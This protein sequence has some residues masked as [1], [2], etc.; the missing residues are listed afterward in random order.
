LIFLILESTIYKVPFAI[1]PAENL[2]DYFPLRNVE[3]NFI[4]FHYVSLTFQ[5]PQLICDRFLPG[6]QNTFHIFGRVLSTLGHSVSKGFAYQLQNQVCQLL[7]QKF[8]LF[9]SLFLSSEQDSLLY[10]TQTFSR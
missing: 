2:I 1:I 4:N 3:V 10:P 7:Y 5:F 9:T 8:D 6:F